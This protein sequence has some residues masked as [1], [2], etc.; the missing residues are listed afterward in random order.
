M[1]AASAHRIIDTMAKEIDRSGRWVYAKS[2]GLAASRLDEADAATACELILDAMVKANA[3]DKR[4]YV[5]CAEALAA[6]APRLAEAAVRKAARVA[7]VAILDAM[8]R[9]SDPLALPALAKALDAV[10][11]LLDAAGASAAA[12]RIPDG[13]AVA[14]VMAVAN[15]KDV[16]RALP[17]A[18]GTVSS[19][20]DM[21]GVKASTQRILDAMSKE[22]MAEVIKPRTLLSLAEALAAV[23]PRLDE[24]EARNAARVAARAILDAIG[25]IN[26]LIKPTDNLLLYDLPALAEALGAVASWLDP[27]D[28]KGAA[29]SLLDAMAKQAVAKVIKPDALLSLGKAFAAVASRLDEAEARSA[30]RAAGQV[31]LDGMAA[32][33]SSDTLATLTT[34]LCMVGP[35]TDA[36]VIASA[37]ERLLDA[38]AKR[39]ANLGDLL[40]LARALCAV[41]P[42]MSHTE[43]EAA[44]PRLLDAMA[45]PGRRL[46]LQPLAEALAAVAA[47]LDEVAAR[48]AARVAAM[49]ILNA[50]GE[51][52]MAKVINPNSLLSLAKAVAAVAPRLDEA[53]A[54]AAAERVIDAMAKTRD[55]FALG[56]LAEALD[57]LTTGAARLDEA[58]VRDAAASAAE[59]I[60]DAMAKAE[61]NHMTFRPLAEALSRVAPRSDSAAIRKAAAAASRAII[62]AMAK[63]YYA[64]HNAPQ[65][66]TEA[67]AIVAGRLDEAGGAAAAWLLLDVIGRSPD[68]TTDPLLLYNRDWGLYS[69]K[70][71]PLGSFQVLFAKLNCQRKVD[72]LKHPACVGPA[73]EAVLLEIG[74]QLNHKFADEWELVDW[75]AEHNPEVD[76][77]T[78]PQPPTP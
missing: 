72:L 47:R 4:P 74:K 33:D 28:A 55:P 25:K 51:E 29:Q 41:A 30:A 37:S 54:K 40:P 59:A 22:A 1:D 27:A 5:G 2:L 73:R 13:I 39:T 75:L 65:D 32:N 21:A 15:F 24:A 78:P 77:L 68:P 76:V 10:A 61:A 60:V 14:D 48:K 38:V 23:A 45:K 35:R 50:L 52:T 9:E 66:L 8:A 70:T 18:L 44:A 57:A 64:G 17:R 31:V 7:A 69:V 6:L 3:S 20:M 49:L 16:L 11:P 26:T 19:R 43:A 71:G 36:A 42:R 56:G 63:Y 53:G 58:V 46:T 12:Q 62:D 67:L 34:V